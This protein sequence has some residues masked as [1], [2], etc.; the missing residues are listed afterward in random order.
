MKSNIYG[1][2]TDTGVLFTDKIVCVSYGVPFKERGES[3]KL[4]RYD[5]SDAPAF[6]ENTSLAEASRG[7]FVETYKGSNFDFASAQGTLLFARES[8]SAQLPRMLSVLAECLPVGAI[9]APYDKESLLILKHAVTKWDVLFARSARVSE[10]ICV[11]VAEGVAILHC[12]STALGD[13]APPK[14]LT[15]GRVGTVCISMMLRPRVG[16]ELLFSKILSESLPAKA[17]EPDK[18]TALGVL[19]MLFAQPI[20]FK[21]VTQPKV[22]EPV[23]VPVTTTTEAPAVAP[24]E[25]PV[26]PAE[27]PAAPPPAPKQ[28]EP[29]SDSKLDARAAC[30]LFEYASDG[31][32]NEAAES[33]SLLHKAFE[34]WPAP[35]LKDTQARE[36]VQ[37][38]V[39]YLDS[40]KAQFPD[41]DVLREQRIEVPGVIQGTADVVLVDHD[42]DTL[43]VMDFKTTQSLGNHSLQLHAYALGLL[44]G[45]PGCERLVLHVIA[46]LALDEAGTV[47]A[48]YTGAA[49]VNAALSATHAAIASVS[50]GSTACAGT[51][52]ANCEHLGNCA[53]A[54]RAL[55]SVLRGTHE[56]LSVKTD[57][58]KLADC[59]IKWGEAIKD[60]AKK[61]LSEGGRIKGWAFRS[62]LAP[63]AV[64]N[65]AA[66]LQIIRERGDS[67]GDDNLN[68]VLNQAADESLS[69][70]WGKFSK[71]LRDAGYGESIPV[72]AGLLG[73][74]L[75]QRHSAGRLVRVALSEETEEQPA[76]ATEEAPTE[77]LSET[78]TI[79]TAEPVQQDLGFQPTDTVQQEPALA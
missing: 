69:M 18:D 41:A 63:L 22:S 78:T 59:A 2:S 32:A 54:K 16:H 37:R 79:A 10:R 23:Q 43:H 51:Q 64:N 67:S 68:D 9:C 56:T 1:V 65:A 6:S 49:E 35:W 30:P 4:L 55:V 27:E 44:H 33:G 74:N 52:C 3:Y 47:I 57:R 72:I 38:G 45:T 15:G 61:T 5:G 46:P 39:E 60:A 75:S 40:V 14:E 13:P 11:R 8:K 42:T 76:N 53:E 24:A 25:A 31:G 7:K 48:E 71:W 50:L 12:E 66:A 62:S 73:N 20:L 19:T 29:L 58:I 70:S 36:I 26:A 77:T 34:T 28:R 21:K 17:K